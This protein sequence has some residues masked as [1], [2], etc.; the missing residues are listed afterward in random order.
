MP[1]GSLDRMSARGGR[2]DAPF[3]LV[4]GR[5]PR[6][7]TSGSTTRSRPSSTASR[8]PATGRCSCS[9]GRA[10][11]RRRRWSRRSRPASTPGT[12]ARTDPHADVLAARGPGAA[13]PHRR[14]ARPHRRGAVRLDLPRVRLRPRRRDAPARGR[15]PPAAAALRARAGRRGARAAGRRPGRRAARVAGGARG[16]ARHPRLRRRGPHP[17]RPGPRLRPR[18]ARPGAVRRRGRWPRRLA[19]RRALPR[20][21]P[22]RPR[23]ARVRST[24]PSWSIGR[25]STPSRP[26]GRAALR[27]RYDLVVVDEYQDT[28]PAQ[29][30]LLTRSPATAATSSSSATPTSRSTPSAAPRCAGCSTSAPASC[31][32]TA[33]PRGVASLRVSRRAGADLLAASRSVARRMP[34]AGGG[35]A[36]ALREHRALVARR[37]ARPPARSTSATYPSPSAQLDAVADLLRRE[38]LDDG[39]AV[40]ADGGARPV[41][42]PVAARLVRRVLGAAGVPGRGG[43]P[44]SSRWPA[45]R[46]WPRCCSRCEVVADAGG[47]TPG[48]RRRPAAQPRSAGWT[49]PGCAGSGRLLRDEERAARTPACPGPAP[50]WSARSLA[51]PERLVA[52]DDRRSSG[53]AARPRRPLLQQ[54]RARLARRRL[55]LRRALA[56]WNGTAWPRRLERAVVGRWSGRSRGRPR[57]RRR[58]RPVRGRARGSRSAPSA[59]APAPSS[60][61]SRPS[62]SR[63]TPSPSARLRGDAV[64]L[65]TAHRSKG[66]EWDLVVVVDVQEDGWPDLRRRGSLLEADRLARRRAGRRRAAPAELLAEERRLF[67]V[68]VTRARRRLVV[69]AVD[70]PEDDGRG[71]R[72]SW[73]S[74]ASRSSPCAERPRRPLT[75]A[76]LVAELRGPPRADPGVDARRCA[77]RLAD[78][79]RGSRTPSDDGRSSCPAAHPDRWWGLDDLTDPQPP[80]APRRRA[81][82]AVRLVAVGARRLPAAVVPRPRGQGR[83][84]PA[85]TALGLRLGRPR[86]RRRRRQ[87]PS[88]RRRRRAHGAGRPGV[89]RSSRSRPGGSPTEPAHRGPHGPRAVPALAQPSDRGPRRSSAP[90]I[91]SHVSLTV[92]DREVVLRG[93]MDRVELDADGRVVVVDLKTGKNPP[94]GPKVAEHP[95]LGRL[96]AGRARGRG[97]RPGRPRRR[98]PAGGAELVQLR[99]RQ[100]GRAAQGAGQA[101]ARG[102]D[103]GTGRRRRHRWRPPSDAWSARGL[104]AHPGRRAAAMCQFRR[105][106]RRATRAGRWSDDPLRSSTGRTRP[107]APTVLRDL[108]EL[109]LHRRAAGRGHRAARARRRRR[110]CRLRQDHR[111]GRPRRVAGR[112]R[113]RSAR[114]R[115][116]GLTFT[117]KAAAELAVRLRSALALLP[118]RLPPADGAPRDRR[119]AGRRRAERGDLPRLRGPAAARARAADRRRAAGARCSPTRR[120]SSS[121]SGCCGARPGR[122][123][124]L[125]HDRR[126][127]WSATIV[128]LDGELSEHLV[129]RRTSCAATTL[130]SSAR[131]GPSPKP[132]VDVLKARDARA[133]AGRAR[134]GRRAAPRGEGRSSASS[135]SATRS[136]GRPARPRAPVG[137][138]RR[139]RALP[140]VLLDEYQ[141]TSVAQRVL[142]TALFGGAATR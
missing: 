117:N 39:T 70:S 47:L 63:P 128:A 95:Q 87:G 18:A 59:A 83:S 77:G 112:H 48:G 134:A 27:A 138:R 113:A 91:G 6:R 76:A 28:D 86:A 12:A 51:E 123:T 68:A 90:S 120:A 124:T 60:T 57:P 118:P 80:A 35:L 8:A 135:T 34:L 100:Q 54:A 50:S 14:P 41:R 131:S 94:T 66:L 141:D 7:S 71:P 93:S 127:T 33:S 69:T 114:S 22:R 43:R 98:P 46:P 31:T 3:R 23:R 26:A 55:G 24:T 78:V 21:L 132:V 85:S 45:S 1:S 107:D 29:E 81:D 92:G 65:L 106:A 72:G 67:Y 4:A 84:P 56:L 129:D 121:P 101:S 13:R 82:P 17:A 116:S 136:R 16:R 142:L 20:Q 62:R 119:A 5:C 111:D 15:R 52:L 88:P 102:P 2:S 19:G 139:A 64:R 75:L 9:P 37:R 99:G 32:A 25:S 103:D 79:W 104:P 109:D 73:P 97:R 140:V 38:H 89:G 61:S 133:P 122:S 137:R 108:L 126:P 130:A 49:P 125:G 36:G 96:P 11:A 58:G 115:C 105:P 110:R 42:G 74:S 40:V 53:P 10:P 44:T 30:R